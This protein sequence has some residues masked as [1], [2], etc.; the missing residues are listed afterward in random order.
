MA[1]ILINGLAYG[2]NIVH[3]SK[4]KSSL[5]KTLKYV[6]DNKLRVMFLSIKKVM[7]ILL[8]TSATS[9]SVERANS[10]LSFSKTDCRRA[11]SEDCFNAPLLLCTLGHKTW[12]WSYNTNVC[13]EIS[14]QAVIAK[15]TVRI[16]K[17]INPQRKNFMIYSCFL[18]F[19]STC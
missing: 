6:S 3:Q 7:K 15:P 1:Q 12:L 4:K 2:W 16:W 14:S 11:M 18:F 13:K 5:S 9:A 8:T 17:T 10:S 19:N